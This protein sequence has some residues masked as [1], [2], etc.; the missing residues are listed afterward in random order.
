MT[1]FLNAAGLASIHPEPGTGMR[2]HRGSIVA[3]VTSRDEAAGDERSPVKCRRR[4]QRQPCRGWIR[5]RL[6]TASRTILWFCPV[7][8]DNG[9]IRGWQRTLWDLSDAGVSPPRSSAVLGRFTEN[10]PIA[11]IEPRFTGPAESLWNAIETHVRVRLLNN[12][13][14][15]QCASS[16]SIQLLEGRVERGDLVL[17]GRC[18]D[19]GGEVARVVESG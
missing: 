14:C 2:D 16:S 9:E 15:V 4:P 8:G 1:H 17:R 5:A 18:I 11:T 12:V 19:C 3:F 10:P 7:C 6:D 13:W